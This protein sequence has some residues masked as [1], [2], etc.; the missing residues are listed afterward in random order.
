M[1]Y[2]KRTL[3]K[4]T[5]VWLAL[6]ICFGPHRVQA[7][8]TPANDGTGTLVNTNSVNSKQFDITGGTQSGENLFHSFQ[9]FGLNQGQIANFLSNPNIQNILGRVVGGDA[10]VINGL[11]QVTGGNSNLYLMNPAGIIF[12]QN[13]SLNVP[14]A[15]TATT[16]NGIGFGNN[17]WFNAVGNN[18]YANLSGN[19]S[20]F[21]FTSNQLGSI[22][23]AGN[24]TVGQGQNL[25]IL[26]GTIVNTGTI[27]APGGN[28][29]IAAVPGERLVSIGFFGSLLSLELP[30]QTAVNAPNTSPK[31]LPELL[32]GGNTNDATGVSVENGRVI[33]TSSGK[34]IP[35]DTGTNIVSGNVSASAGKINILGEKVGLIGANVDVS[36]KNGGGTVLVGG[37]YQGKGTVPNSQRTV[38]SSNTVINANATQNGDGGKV[39]V[40]ADGSTRFGG[41][42]TARGG[43]QG[44]NGGLV[45]TSGKNHLDV[46][47]GKV[48]AGASNGLAGTWLL[49]PTDINIVN[50]ASGTID[51]YGYFE[52]FDNSNIS[53]AT[54]ESALNDG[55]NVII[56]TSYGNGGN[57]DITLTDSIFQIEGG[58]A[59][60]TLTG[61]RFLL[62]SSSPTISISSTGELTFDI[63]QVNPEETT[64]T[65]S[66]NNA[67][68]AIG[69]VAGNRTINLGA[70]TY[71]GDTVNLNKNVTINGVGAD[72][73]TV[74]GNNANRVFNVAY[75]TNATLQN[76][77]VSKGNQSSSGGG[78][79]NNGILTVNN[80]TIKDNVSQSL[81]G[82]GGGGGG[83]FNA[84]T[85]TATVNNSTISGNSSQSDGGG[86]FN[87]GGTITL[88][89][90]TISNNSAQN[91]GGGIHNSGILG[92]IFDDEFS[93]PS[94]TGSL[95][96][97]GSLI[98]GNSAPTGSEIFNDTTLTEFTSFGYNIFGNSDN[99]GL[100]GATPTATD[101]V[102]SV[103]LD[104]ILAPLANNG[105]LTQTHALVAGSPAIDAGA[106]D[107]TLT[108]DQRGG[109]RG[110]GG[111]NSG[112]RIDIGAYEVTSSSLVT[113][114]DDDINAGSLRSAINFTNG[115]VNPVTGSA[116][117]IVLFDTNGVFGNPQTIS[118]TQ[119]KLTLNNTQG[120]TTIQGT[121][122]DK[123]TISG[124]GNW[125]VFS[126]ELGASA[127]LQDLTVT[128]GRFS[129]IANNGGTLTVN[130]SNISGNFS[131]KPF[132]ASNGIANFSGT[133]TVNDSNINGNSGSGISNYS[134]TSTV[135]NSNISGN[136]DSAFSNI[137]GILNVNNVT[138][139]NNSRRGIFSFGTL[140]VSNSNISNNSET[141]IFV[142]S[143]TLAVDNS[144]ISN[145]S[146][147]GIFVASGTLA[148][149]KSTISNN[150]GSGIFVNSGNTL[151]N[152]STI[153]HNISSTQGGGIFNSFGTLTISNSNI[154]SNTSSI[155]AGIMSIGTLT[156]SDSA[157]DNNISSY[158]GGGIYHS[159]NDL[160]IS[161][162]TI[163]G[164]TSSLGG[165]IFAPSATFTIRNSIFSDNNSSKDGGAIYQS[166][167]ISTISD[168]T[169][170]NN[171]ASGDGGAIYESGGIST[172]SD[173]TLS[174]NT[175]KNNGGGIYNDGGTI[176]VKNSTLSNNSAQNNGGGIHNIGIPEIT[177]DDGFISSGSTGNLLVGN[178]LIAGNT[179]AIGSEIFNDSTLASFTSLGYNIFGNSNNSG[180][181]G[182]T[183]TD[184]D[185]VPSVSVKQIIA[186]LGNY[187]GTTQTHAL[188]PGSLAINA[189]DPNVTTPDQR[190][191]ARVGRADIGAFE[192]QGFTIK[193]TDGD[194]QSTTV[195]QNFNN[196][197]TVTVTANDPNEPVAGGV[198]TY[199]ASTIGASANL[200]ANQATINASG[201]A[202][203]TAKAN[204]TTGNYGVNVGSNG[205]AN[206]TTFNLTN[207][208]DAPASITAMAGNN[209]NTTV[210]N[211]FATNLQALVKDQYGNVV[212]NAK[213]TF[214]TPKSGASAITNNTITTDINGQV[215][216]P[217]KANTIAGG[218]TVS[219]GDSGA[220]A[221]FSLT[222][223]PDK[224]SKITA[225]A[226]NNQST[227][228]NTQF[229]TNLQALVTDQYG[230]AIPN[231]SIT[232][233]TPTS[234]A[235]GTIAGSTFN[236][237]K[238]GQ[239]SIPVT[240]NTI[241][242][243]YIIGVYINGVA[244]GANFNLTNQLET[245]LQENLVRLG[246]DLQDETENKTEETLENTDPVLCVS[247]QSRSE[248]PRLPICSSN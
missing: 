140:R 200:S 198:V 57:G 177:F 196:P 124:A 39:I 131:P 243:S 202:S 10:S 7:Q 231:A 215:S 35:S 13:A 45:E 51:D 226:G 149:D 126:N 186:P 56:S 209:Q 112:S 29:T 71:E 95:S 116:D 181:N 247:A 206:T 120:T 184:T 171:K 86:I 114:T 107:S 15:F 90:S 161:N 16:A 229:A 82:L 240:A 118:L 113:R 213:I 68:S 167:G 60:L 217:V 191:V 141:G 211:P 224:P 103:S 130:N 142:A 65:D 27:S 234:G 180:L 81:L 119:G 77:T 41:R 1:H 193:T 170:T 37:D 3:I 70:G 182:A 106:P 189:G 248:F 111:I 245:I 25:T 100:S 8:I 146:G 158:Y 78:I 28:I 121:G 173:S 216:I 36:G 85:A 237:N 165:G 160:K 63:N 164:N 46:M 214:T 44:G 183:P 155:G 235:S 192:S 19:P 127:I 12:G 93:L 64:N 132:E 88:K 101:I 194:N 204:T 138:A 228:V 205:I 108:T 50:G 188:L 239:V 11:I 230:N 110:T 135:N 87:N 176:T 244:E 220:S 219:L 109:Q 221:Q 31:S 134:G 208:A 84:I 30:A 145:N 223:N 58:D 156:I 53:P 5:L 49:D 187:G 18:N 75:N 17:L 94:S 227:V 172:I 83:I 148:V 61:R 97:G 69:T 104:K 6:C 99:S 233:T 175:A 54:I 73:T 207:Q 225:T 144:I 162:S 174:G 152:K 212:P 169:F 115:N 154:N 42:I 139:S 203:I 105:G 38:I 52:P 136:S 2:K 102:P 72:S 24:L 40:W 32:T 21:A 129:G 133:L 150:S 151:V 163:S 179:A 74:S 22:F 195:N 238:N 232:F 4:T 218:Y 47:G 123:L 137:G 23:N 96:I 246:R 98:S 76:L 197:L 92:F 48:D 62:G 9:Q 14:A 67:I 66:I 55:T 147:R 79:Y 20:D 168:S 210:N 26:G 43:I 125:S 143:G 242:D 128:Q 178:N 59:S 157:I 241:P 153:S 159:G 34:E 117:N 33:L 190:G 185:I 89:N 122:K 91:N 80:S 236:T 199:T 166:G 222:N 201:Q